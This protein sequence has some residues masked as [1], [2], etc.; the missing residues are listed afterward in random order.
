MFLLVLCARPPI[1]VVMPAFNVERYIKSAL[2]S[3]ISQNASLIEIIIINDGA[4]DNTDQIIHQIF[5]N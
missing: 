2:E 5:E 1:S 4:T 3:T